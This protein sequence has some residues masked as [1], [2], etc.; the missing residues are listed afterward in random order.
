LAFVDHELSFSMETAALRPLPTLSL[1]DGSVM[2]G[3]MASTNSTYE[4][5]RVERAR[6]SAERGARPHGALED[7]AENLWW[8][9]GSPA[10]GG[11]PRSMVLAR[12]GDGDL[13]MHGTVALDRRGMSALEAVGRPRYLL[14]PDASMRHD[15]RVLAE[16]FPG[17]QVFA[18]RGAH[19]AIAKAMRV[20]GIF[21]DFPTDDDVSIRTLHGIGDARGT[22][23][24][25]SADGVT[26][27]VGDVLAALARRGPLAMLRAAL[28]GARAMFRVRNGAALARDLRGH[29]EDPDLARL[30]EGA[31]VVVGRAEAARQLEG[32]TALL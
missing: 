20:D 13:V 18:P 31:R 7:L 26:V 11:P 27:V 5:V 22:L 21:E 1:R 8:T 17:I 19:A 4:S 32:A 16:R 12:R 15:A 14:V 3:A 23:R 28:L 24:V 9:W 30:V 6:R 25:R 2:T 29:A 10:E